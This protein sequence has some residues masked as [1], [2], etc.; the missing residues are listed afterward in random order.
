VTLQVVLLAG[1]LG[2][3]MR[4][5]TETVP[6][7][8]IP[9]S[10]R[11][12]ADWQ[13]SLLAAQGVKRVVYSIG[14]RGDLLRDHVGDG[15]RFGLEVSWIDEGPELRGTGGALRLALDQGALDDAF[16]VLWGDSYLT[17]DFSSVEEAWRRSGLPALM[18]VLHNE[19][20]W[21][22][23]NAIYSNGRIALYDKARPEA[24]QSEMHWIDYGLSVLTRDVVNQR[25][26]T[27]TV[28]DLAEVMRDLSRAGKLAGL[29]VAQRFY[30]VGSPEG[31]RDLEAYLSSLR[32]RG[33]E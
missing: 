21:G 28:A 13:L 30:E 19:G 23:S 24:R 29:E 20:R 4:P 18:T 2:T 8:L 14:Y 3:R 16:F 32:A 31:V 7:A 11:P 10:G 33:S 27:A 26:P 22:P 15:S 17:I 25:I 6:K 5:M 12:F 9:V 1:G